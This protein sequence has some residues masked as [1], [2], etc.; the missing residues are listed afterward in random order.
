MGA[1]GEG[2][3]MLAAAGSAEV[4][5]V[6][7]GSDELRENWDG[8]KREFNADFDKLNDFFLQVLTGK[9]E[10]EAVERRASE[11]FGL[12]GPWY[13]VGYQMAVMVERRYGRAVLIDCMRDRRL[14]LVRYNA[15]AL[16]MN[17][18]AQEPGRFPVWSGEILEA[19]AVPR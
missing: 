4:D 18:S 10:G 14:L 16:E 2:E 8:G 9:L 13:T 6:A 12:Q 15:A 7:S 5:P 17:R 19:T 3:A 11:F 1:F